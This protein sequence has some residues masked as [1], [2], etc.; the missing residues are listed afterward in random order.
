LLD[1]IP[2]HHNGAAFIRQQNLNGERGS[3]LLFR[4]ERLPGRTETFEIDRDA[5]H[6]LELVDG[7]R[8]VREIARQAE[9]AAPPRTQDDT[10][11]ALTRYLE[12]NVL[13]W[14]PPS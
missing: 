11:R 9:E 10:V 7:Q 8:S 6:I 3:R 1:V 4:Y 14:R 5:A 13:R 2:E 12:Q